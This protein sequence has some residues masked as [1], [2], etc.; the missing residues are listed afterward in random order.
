MTSESECSSTETIERMQA[1]LSH[2]RACRGMCSQML[3]AGNVGVDRAEFATI[4]GRGVRLEIVHVHVRR[5]AGQIDHDGRLGAAQGVLPPGR[6][7]LRLRSRSMS[8]RV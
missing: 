5:A 8:A 3:H 7:G 6:S 2:M 1:S 4:F